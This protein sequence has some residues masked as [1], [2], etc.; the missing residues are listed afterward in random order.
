M[1]SAFHGDGFGIVSLDVGET[2]IAERA[3]RIAIAWRAGTEGRDG[4]GLFAGR[5]GRPRM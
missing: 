5:G 4:G 3:K 1:M 2:L